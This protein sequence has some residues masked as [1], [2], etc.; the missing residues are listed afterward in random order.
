MHRKFFILLTLFMTIKSFAVAI[1]ILE[2]HN[3]PRSIAIQYS[4]VTVQNQNS[5]NNS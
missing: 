2:M 3:P 1:V 4:S 5:G